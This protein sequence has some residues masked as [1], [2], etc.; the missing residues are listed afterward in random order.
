VLK[1]SQTST[2]TVTISQSPAA[3]NITLVLEAL[4]I[5][6][7]ASF[8]VVRIIRTTKLLKNQFDKND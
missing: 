7:I 5:S 8:A 1:V 3:D 4:F 2:F 6:A